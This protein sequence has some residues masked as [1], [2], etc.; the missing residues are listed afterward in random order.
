[1]NIDQ[2]WLTL[3]LNSQGNYVAA[4]CHLYL[5]VCVCVLKAYKCEMIGH[6]KPV[7]EQ[8]T[9]QAWCLLKRSTRRH[10]QQHIIMIPLK[11]KSH[12]INEQSVKW[13]DCKN[14]HFAPYGC[15]APDEGRTRWRCSSIFVCAVRS[16][17]QRGVSAC[18]A[19][20]LNSSQTALLFI[21]AHV[22]GW[23]AH[24]DDRRFEDG[25]VCAGGEPQGEH[26]CAVGVCGD[27]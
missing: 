19:P 6:R 5:S 3:P 9:K 21:V 24:T 2:G 15:Y 26:C 4:W 20:C 8:N 1:M 12:P 23:V 22:Y 10:T 11:A 25:V 16:P 14:N 7:S 13:S 18:L 27:M 17:T